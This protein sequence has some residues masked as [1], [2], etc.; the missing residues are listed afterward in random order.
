[1]QA[2][3]K[4]ARES[5][6]PY[7]ASRD[8]LLRGLKRHNLSRCDRERTLFSLATAEGKTRLLALL[9]KAVGRFIDDDFAQAIDTSM[10]PEEG[11]ETLI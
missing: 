5:G 8:A 11:E 6:A 10:L 1:M 4:F 3:A 2:V 7:S 9:V